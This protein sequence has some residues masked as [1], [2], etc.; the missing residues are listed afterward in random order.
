M[1][2][3]QNQNMPQATKIKYKYDGGSVVITVN[4]SQYFDDLPLAKRVEIVEQ[5]L[6]SA[7]LDCRIR[8][9]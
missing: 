3:D 1:N 5:S 4:I 6:K 7:V 9:G 8:C 2:D